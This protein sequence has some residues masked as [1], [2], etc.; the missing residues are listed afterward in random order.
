MEFRVVA[1]AWR[2]ITKSELAQ[3]SF[4]SARTPASR[5][6]SSCPDRFGGSARLDHVAGSAA[7]RAV[8]EE[9][10]RIAGAAAD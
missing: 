3:E 6:S 5:A 4:P 8:I 7:L 10:D 9:A 1:Q 2:A